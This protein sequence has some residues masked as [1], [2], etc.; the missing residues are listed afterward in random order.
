MAATI[1]AVD[2]SPEIHR[3]LDVR[4]QGEGVEL[5]HALDG[6]EALA[7]VQERQP[8]LV[9]LDVDLPGIDGFEVCARLKRDART[10][11]IPV[12]FLTGMG[13]A[14]AKARGL[15][16]GAVDFVNKPFDPSELR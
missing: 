5:W 4:L 12:V 8:D 15:D 9:L 13:D 2:D 16:L 11:D 14:E 7:L 10:R 3:L 6:P 1:L